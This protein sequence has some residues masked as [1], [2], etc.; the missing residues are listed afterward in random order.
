[1]SAVEEKTAAHQGSAGPAR[2]TYRSLEGVRGFRLEAPHARG[3]TPAR[4]VVSIEPMDARSYWQH[5]GRGKW[6]A[7][8]AQY[9]KVE[10]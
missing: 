5:D 4:R 1:M 2:R 7:A 3:A 10:S 6:D 9:T 8:D